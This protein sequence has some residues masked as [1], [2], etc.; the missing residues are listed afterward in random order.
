MNV[1]FVLALPQVLEGGDVGNR[2]ITYTTILGSVDL[3]EIT[4]ACIIT[5]NHAPT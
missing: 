4:W 5:M 2:L 3:L 1:A